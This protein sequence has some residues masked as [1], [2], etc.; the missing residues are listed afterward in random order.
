MILCLANGFATIRTPFN[1]KYD[2][3]QKFRGM[4]TSSILYNQPVDFMESGLMQ[5]DKWD[6]WHIDIPFALNTDEAVPA[7]VNNCFIGANHG[8]HGAVSVYAPAHGKTVAD[9]GSLWKDENGVKFTLMRVSTEDHLLFLSENTGESVEN[10]AFIKKI[11]GK[12]TY[13]ENGENT[14]D[15]CPEKQGSSDLRRAIRYKDKRAVAVTNGKEHVVLGEVSC[16]YAEIR[17]EYEIINPATVAEALR[18]ARPKDGYQKQP[19]FADYG[20]PMLSCKITYRIENDGTILTLFDYKKLMNV[21]F[22]RF[23]GIMYQEKLDVYKG[24]IWRYFPKVLPFTTEEGTFNFSM[25]T[26]TVGEPFPKRFELTREY[27]KDNGSPC[28]RAVDYFRDKN[29]CDRL[30]FASGFLP[31][32][33]GVPTIRNKQV[34]NVVSLKFTRKHYPTFADGDLTHIRGIG[35]KKYF[36]PTADKASYYKVKAE[37]KTFIYADFFAKKTLEIPVQGNMKPFEVSEGI[38]YKTESGKIA[39][40]GEH[41]YA[42]F[43]EE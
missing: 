29:G 26:P 36:T 34:S 14:A 12:L 8:H 15:I 28:E 33:D 6:Y 43:V 18:A 10:Y 27:W 20:Q 19:D 30:A 9:V 17:E 2:L 11:E 37:G 39:V 25:P 38:T 23:M 5:R 31:L 32:Y 7:Y 4:E 40:T 3:I 21:R 42:V 41:G 22:Q 16:D 35:Y 24:G 13:L 1:E